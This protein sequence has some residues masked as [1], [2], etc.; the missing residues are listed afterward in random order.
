MKQKQKRKHFETT[1]S[2]KVLHVKPQ[3]EKQANIIKDL[4]KTNQIVAWMDKM[5][6]KCPEVVS[7]IKIR[8]VEDNPLYVL[9]ATETYGKNKIMT[10]L[11]YQMNFNVL[12]V[13]SIDGY[14]WSWT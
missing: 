4:A 3:D 5:V 13:F 12:P 8:T 7:H 10:K 6:Q 11:L 1:R 9:K 2:E 14:I